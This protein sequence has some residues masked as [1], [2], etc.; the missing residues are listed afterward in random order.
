MAVT[1]VQSSTQPYDAAAMRRLGTWRALGRKPDARD[2]NVAREAASLLTSQLF[3]AP[4]LAEMRKLPFG[5][6][7]GHGGRMEDAFG[8]QWDMRIA[9]TV[10]RSDRGLTAQL[11]EKLIR[12]QASL[13]PDSRSAEAQA[14]AADAGGDQ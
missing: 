3:F 4:L 5:K 9:D 11:A 12:T 10:A 13:N 7:F 1:A 14:R 6:E 2:P 8:E